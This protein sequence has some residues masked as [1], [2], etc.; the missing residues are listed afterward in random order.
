[1][2]FGGGIGFPVGKGELGFDARYILGLSTIDDTTASDEIKTGVFNFN[3]Y[4]GF[5]F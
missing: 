2:V 5:S 1:L 3:I 4:Y